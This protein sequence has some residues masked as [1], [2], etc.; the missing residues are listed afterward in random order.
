MFKK[1]VIGIFIVLALI[2]S[3]TPAGN[4][5]D[6][7]VIVNNSVA[8]TEISA[9]D[10]SNIFLGKKKSWD[11]GQKAVPVTLESGPTHE[12]FMKTYLK[13]SASQFSTFWKQAIFTGQGIPPKSV[14]SE[15]DVVKFVSENEGAVGYILSSTPHD[16]VK[17]IA[18][19]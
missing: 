5:D 11:G 13:K 3:F 4:A 1:L 6:V 9:K 18:V 17:T 19:K 12:N 7:I 8:Q 2:V 10:L 14:N 15:N 16:N